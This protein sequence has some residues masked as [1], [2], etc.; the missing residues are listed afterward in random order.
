MSDFERFAD[1]LQQHFVRQARSIYTET[2][3]DHWLH[4]RNQYAMEKPDGRGKVKGPC[5]DTM[6][7]FLK[8]A[9]NRIVQASFLTDGCITS[10]AAAS[11]TVEMAAGRSIGNAQT[12]TKDSILDALGGL[13]EEARHCALLGALTLKAA[14]DDFVHCR[15]GRWR[16]MYRR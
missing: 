4:P 11:M 1:D 9:E 2:V 13:P 15:S 7:I 6:E 3:V 16:E 14:L 12:I 8:V 10:I 5:G